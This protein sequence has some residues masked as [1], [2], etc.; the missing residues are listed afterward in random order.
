MTF[1][2]FL[3]VALIV[4]SFSACRD[5]VDDSDLYTF[6]GETAYSFLKNA[7][8]YSDYAY[9][10]SK[11]KLSKRSP[12]TVAELLSA[13]GNYTVFAPNN[14]AIESYL[15]SIYGVS[16]Y[17]ITQ[18]PDSTAEFIAKNSIIDNGD[19]EAYL[20]TDFVVGALSTTNMNNRYIQINYDNDASGALITRVNNKSKIIVP[21]NEVYNGVVH[22]I[23]HVVDMSASSL[24][25]LIKNTDNLRIFSKLLELTGWADSMVEYLDEY[26]EYNHPEFGSI[27][28]GNTSGGEQGPSP[29][30]RFIGFTAFVETDSL[31]EAQWNIPAPI[32]N[33]GSVENYDEIIDAVKAK[34]QEA[35]PQATAEDMKSQDNAV[36]QFVSYHLLPMRIIYNKLVI[37]KNEMGY[38]WKSPEV[39]TINCW[40]YYETMGNP[41]RLIKLTEG[42]QTEGKRINRY[43]QYENGFYDS[44]REK[45]THRPG[46]LIYESNG[47]RTTNALNGFYYPVSEILVY[48]EEV[49]QKVLNERLRFDFAAICP[50][51]MTNGQRQVDDTDWRF[52][53][54]GYLKNW[55]Y[56]EDTYWRYVPY[57]NGG[58][59][60]FQCDEINILGQ[61]D[62]TFKLPPVPYEGTWEFRICAPEIQHFGMFQVYLGTDRQNLPP[63]GLPL[64]FRLPSSN[65][66]IGW[67]A[68]TNDLDENREIDKDMR[69]HGYMKNCMHNGR[70]N[71]G[72]AVTLPM[73]AA[74]GDYIRLRKILW[75]GNMSPNETYYVRIKSVLEN[76]RTCC[77]LDYFE[78]V[79]KY[80]YNGPESEDPW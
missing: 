68:D 40:E 20:S 18:I 5:Q 61:Y 54:Q 22:T 28:P 70:P 79:P 62:L 34:C 4:L 27:D 19:N 25:D 37:H 2:S 38:A 9:I 35:Y 31:F 46:A 47:T 59:D 63:I 80:I 75:S 14:K 44:Y 64:D 51:L 36:N 76:T 3:S 33:A 69:N 73:R 30:H 24:P 17:D 49:P 15:D 12:S 11:V 55:W 71:G 8:D 29:E 42:S 43:S 45:P 13:R 48:D 10:L 53:P 52:I 1:K 74:Q 65:P 21:D 26:Y 16:G 50:D 58:N 39:L 78:L 6:T 7:E 41:R 72:S 67:R 60:N 32:V 66:T 23:D 77:M 57:W 56:T